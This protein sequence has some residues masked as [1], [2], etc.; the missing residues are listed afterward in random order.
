TVHYDYF[1]STSFPPEDQ[2]SDFDLSLPHGL[3]PILYCL[4][5][6]VGAVGNAI[7]IGA[8]VFKRGVKRLVD[9][10][11]SHLA[12]SDF[13]FLVTL[14]LWVDKEVVGGPWR[15]GW[16][17]CKFSAYIITLN[18]YSSVFFLT[19]MSLDRFLAA[20]LP[21]QSRVFRTKHNAKVCCTC[22]WMLSA[23][24][25]APVLHSRV[26]KKYEEK[27]YCNEDAGSSTVAFSMI[28]L[29]VAFFLPLAVILSCY[30]TI[31]WKLCHQWQKFHKQQQKLR[32]SLKIV[33]IVVVVFVFSWM[34]FNL[35]RALAIA[36]NLQVEVTCQSYTL[37]RLGMQLTAPLA[38]S[39]SCANPI[40]YAFFDRYIRRAMLQCLCPCIKPPAHWQSSDTSESHLH[41][42]Q[43]TFISSFPGTK[44]K[45]KVRSASL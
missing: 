6:V 2:C 16:F 40:I 39:N 34:P 29:I 18:M 41:K 13:I 44:K 30:C 7:V 31:I 32:R 1:P 45:N 15:S 19:C 9:I 20:V 22:V 36:N 17:F 11:I 27:E 10:F 3:L 35:F 21:L 5:F 12:V 43:S 23:T 37:A 25:A 33:F 14:P 38:F 42:S 28:S 4:V 26:L 8:I 24:L